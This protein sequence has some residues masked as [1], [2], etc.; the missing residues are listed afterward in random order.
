MG[1]CFSSCF[2]SKQPAVPRGIGELA[3][4]GSVKPNQVVPVAGPPAEAGEVVVW[5]ETLFSFIEDAIREGKLSADL[6]PV[7]KNA[8]VP[9]LKEILR[10]KGAGVGGN[11]PELVQ[12]IY[13]V[14]GTPVHKVVPGPGTMLT[15]SNDTALPVRVA[16]AW[17]HNTRYLKGA[18]AELTVGFMEAGVAANV[19]FQFGGEYPP[20]NFVVP[21]GGEPQVVGMLTRRAQVTVD[22]STGVN[23][24]T[25]ATAD[26]GATVRI[27]TPRIKFID[28]NK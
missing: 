19:E 16:V 2:S 22:L 8:T 12:R 15:I 28:K 26:E 25:A 6:R 11:K 9:E 13:D 23:I 7:K 20:S 10:A 24:C 4:P 14:F 1:P 3:P 5:R 17:D 18:G 21:A 27:E